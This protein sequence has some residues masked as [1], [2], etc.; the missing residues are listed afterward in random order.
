M[1]L[2]LP[3]PLSPTSIDVFAVVADFAAAIFSG[4]G[5][6]DVGGCTEVLLLPFVPFRGTVLRGIGRAAL[7][8]LNMLLFVSL[9]APP[10]PEEFD[11]GDISST[12]LDFFDDDGSIMGCRLGL[13][14]FLGIA[15]MDAVVIVVDDDDPRR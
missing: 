5:F 7:V 14:R 3:L 8:V 6:V 12:N 2:S 1:P 9:P 15:V 13:G 4:S 10:F 11:L